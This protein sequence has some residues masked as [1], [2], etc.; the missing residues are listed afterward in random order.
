MLLL[1]NQIYRI[2]YVATSDVAFNMSNVQQF[3]SLLTGLLPWYLHALN[4]EDIGTCKFCS[5]D[6]V[7][8]LWSGLICWTVL[9]VRQS[10]LGR[11]LIWG[12]GLIYRVVLNPNVNFHCDEDL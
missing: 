2:Q 7:F 12:D 1:L 9:F 10:Y 6:K 4:L 8:E 5:S 11:G 3:L